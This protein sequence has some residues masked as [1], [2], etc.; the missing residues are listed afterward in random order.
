MKLIRYFKA[1]ADLLLPRAC[2]VCGERLNLDEKHLCLLCLADMPLTRFWERPYNPMADKFNE[3]IQKRP[4][5]L[6]IF[7]EHEAYAY[8]AALF[9]YR[10]EANYRYIPYQIKYQGNLAVGKQFGRLLGKYL[11]AGPILRDVDTVIPVPLHWTRKWKRGYNQAEIIAEAVAKVLQVRLRTDIL[12][13]K[14]NT[15]SQVKLGVEDKRKNV[16]GAFCTQDV[17]TEG[18]RHILLI[19]DVFTTGSTLESCF[20]SLRSVF[21][22]SVRISIATLG[23]LER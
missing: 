19:D 5:D 8:A 2:I 15:K 3:L 20:N 18:I 4:D 1:A 11:A 7:G 10:S 6:E 23:Y 21:P 14:R 9:L 16:D 22:K 13:R 17:S 12:I